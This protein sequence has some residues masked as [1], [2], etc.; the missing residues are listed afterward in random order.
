MLS[1]NCDIV[2]RKY[3]FTLRRTDVLCSLTALVAGITIISLSMIHTSDIDTCWA[4]ER[5][6]TYSLMLARVGFLVNEA[7]AV[8]SVSN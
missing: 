2:A 6:T 8:V 4:G 5:D 7:K 3:V 1:H